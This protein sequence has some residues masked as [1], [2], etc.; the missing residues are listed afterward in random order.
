[1]NNI[2]LT[3]MLNEAEQDVDAITAYLTTDNVWDDNTIITARATQGGPGGTVNLTCKR[4]IYTNADTEVQKL[5]S[6]GPIY[7]WVEIGDYVGS[8]DFRFIAETWGRWIEFTE[9]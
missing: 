9:Y 1:M 5:G 7:I 2:V 4:R 6:G 8:E 3:L